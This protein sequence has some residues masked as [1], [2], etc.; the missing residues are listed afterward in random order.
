MH[1]ND[2]EIKAEGPEPIELDDVL[3]PGPNGAGGAVVIPFVSA[4]TGSSRARGS[5]HAKPEPEPGGWPT[6]IDLW[7]KLEPPALPRGLLPSVIEEFAFAQGELT[8]ADPGGFA[9]A[10]LCV[11]GAAAPDEMEVQ[12]KQN[13]PSW[14]ESTRLWV[15]LVGLASKKKSPTF[16]ETTKPIVKLDF[17]LAKKHAAELQEYNALSAEDKKDAEPPRNVRLCIDNVTVE[18]VQ[19]VLKDFAS[20]NPK[21]A[22]RAFGLVRRDGQIF[23]RARLAN[24]S[25]VLP[26]DLQWRALWR[27]PHRPRRLHYSEPL[28]VVARRI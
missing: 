16:K 3:G 20:R 21:P 1:T 4:G 22:G 27:R 19:E 14:R 17:E 26:S 23:G 9:A 8:G 2:D 13:D 12:V 7:G 11:C 15:A 5:A 28:D 18:Y 24:G 10:A 6:P 25:G